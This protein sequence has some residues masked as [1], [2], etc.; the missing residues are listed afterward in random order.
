MSSP[1]LPVN[2]RSKLESEQVQK[3]MQE[4]SV[5]QVPFATLVFET[6]KF[7]PI[8]H[9]LL[10]PNGVLS[11]PC[12][13]SKLNCPGLSQI[14]IIALIGH[15][16]I[17]YYIPQIYISG[18]YSFGVIGGCQEKAKQ[19]CLSSPFSLTAVT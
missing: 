8:Y 7:Y 3:D 5:W 13:V 6:G 14:E 2:D 4:T 15:S 19:L 9:S 10:V 17:P 18:Y 11:Y 1:A 12:R 16:N